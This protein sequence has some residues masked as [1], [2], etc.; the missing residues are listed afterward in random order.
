MKSMKIPKSTRRGEEIFFLLFFLQDN[1]KARVRNLVGHPR[2]SSSPWSFQPSITGV[3]RVQGLLVST[4]EPIPRVWIGERIFRKHRIQRQ[5]TR[6][7]DLRLR[8]TPTDNS[9]MFQIITVK[10]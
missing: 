7:E 6:G 10:Y 5:C 8:I 4:K 1:V 3:Q 2:R 9:N